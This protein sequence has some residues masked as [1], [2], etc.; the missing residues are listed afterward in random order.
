MWSRQG[1]GLQW[2]RTMSDAIFDQALAWHHKQEDDDF[3]WDGFTVW[4]EADPAHRLA[5][6]EVALL[7]A[8]ID[9]HRDQI[10]AILSPTAQAHQPYVRPAR[11]W[12]LIAGGG[13]AAAL[14]LAIGLPMLSGKDPVQDYRTAAGQTQQIALADGSHIALAPFSHL[15]VAGEDQNDMQLEGSAYFDIRHRPERPMTI[16]AGGQQIYDIGTRFDILQSAGTVRVAVAEGQVSV[17]RGD[18]GRGVALTAGR[19]LVVD[20]RS[21]TGDLAT[22]EPGDV[23]SWRAGRLVYDNVPLSLVA[24]DLSRY[25]RQQ[26]KVGEAVAGRRFSGV[27]VVGDGGK[28][29]QD[30]AQIMGLRA[31]RSDGA[32][33]LDSGSR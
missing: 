21:G 19:Q 18:A 30:V 23:G 15:R 4:L 5:F 13:I 25:G 3:D 33:L 32:V 9:D 17:R 6:D 20:D 28:L 2:C 8:R 11:K 27:L 22:V 12:P 16:R 31:S 1:P 29:V 24:A 26:V 14:A 7:D 10:D